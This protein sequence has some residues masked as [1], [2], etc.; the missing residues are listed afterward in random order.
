MIQSRRMKRESYNTKSCSVL[1][2]VR[3]DCR[4]PSVLL[5]RMKR[6]LRVHPP[7]TTN[8]PDS[9]D[10]WGWL[11]ETTWW[12]SSSRETVFV[13]CLELPALNTKRKDTDR[14]LPFGF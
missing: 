7:Y 6:V 2:L 9:R 11:R 4:C 10:L 3:L 8:P 12:V 13:E 1:R 14:G 5:E